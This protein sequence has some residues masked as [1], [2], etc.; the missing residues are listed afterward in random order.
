M[1][2]LVSGAHDVVDAWLQRRFDALFFAIMRLTGCG[3]RQIRWHLWIGFIVPVVVRLVPWNV[4]AHAWLA[5][6]FAV[7]VGV[8]VI[9][10]YGL[11]MHKEHE[12]DYEAERRGMLSAADRPGNA[13]ACKWLGWFYVGIGVVTFLPPWLLQDKAEIMRFCDV[14]AGISMLAQ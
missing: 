14:I 1:W 6:L 9:A 10:F 2:R 8:W 5:W 4:K 11:W 7:P 12:H 3:K 13:R